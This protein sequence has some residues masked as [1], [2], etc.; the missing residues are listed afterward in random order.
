MRHIGNA[1]GFGARVRGANEDESSVSGAPQRFG[2]FAPGAA[3]RIR[4]SR[5]FGL[6][7]RAWSAANRG[8]L[9]AGLSE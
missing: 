4:S 5:A 7:W 6:S 1:D 9:Q 3:A 2:E 8:P